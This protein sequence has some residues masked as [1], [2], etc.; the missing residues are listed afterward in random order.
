MIIHYSIVY[1]TKFVLDDGK[2]CRGAPHE[3]FLYSKTGHITTKLFKCIM[4]ELTK[5]WT[6]THPELHCYLISDN[7]CIHT[8]DEMVSNAKGNSIHLN[9]IMPG[10]SH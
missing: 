10:Y 2:S 8:N 4:D 3:L 1:E 6:A 7:L 9:N 5:W